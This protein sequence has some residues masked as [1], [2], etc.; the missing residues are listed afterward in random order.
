MYDTVIRRQLLP[1]EKV[2]S[3]DKSEEVEKESDGEDLEV[4]GGHS[5][6]ITEHVHL[7]VEL[8]KFQEL[9]GGEEYDKSRHVAVELIIQGEGLE[10]DKLR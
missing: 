4:L 2:A 7:L 1:E 10:V 3:E 5:D 8:K 9:D 6:S